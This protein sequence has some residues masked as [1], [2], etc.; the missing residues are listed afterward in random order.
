VAETDGPVRDGVRWEVV[1]SGT[2][3]SYQSPLLSSGLEI[4]VPTPAQTGVSGLAN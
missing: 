4:T 2:A 3:V 1:G